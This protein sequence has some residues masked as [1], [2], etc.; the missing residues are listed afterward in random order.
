MG[1]ILQ[2][3]FEISVFMTFIYQVPNFFIY[4]FNLTFIL[5]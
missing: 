5:G 3:S 1:I 2:I 4:K